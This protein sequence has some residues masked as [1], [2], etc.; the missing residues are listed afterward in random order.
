MDLAAG[1]RLGPYEIVGAIGAGGMG[2]VY[3][4]RDTRLERCVALKILPAHF[5]SNPELKSRFEREARMLSS[6]AHPYIC[7]LYD[8]GSQNG[9]AYLVM[10]LLQ[11]ETLAERL[12]RGALPLSD[13]LKTGIEVADALTSAHRLGLVH[14]DLKPANIMLTKTGA[15][16]MDFGLAKPAS[17]GGGSSSAWQVSG[18]TLTA[19]RSPGTPITRAGSIVGT[20]QY[21]SPEQLEGKEEDARSDI[22]ALGAVLYEMATGKRAFDGRTQLSVVS[23]ILHHEPE[24]IS[25]IQPTSPAALNY[26][27]CTCLRKDPDERF[28]TAHDVKLQLNWLAQGSGPTAPLA[29]AQVAVPRK[30]PWKIAAAVAAA[31]ALLLLGFALARFSGGGR[32]RDEGVTRLT[33]TLPPKQ[34]LGADITMAEAISPDGK[35]LAYVGVESGLSRLYTRR[36]DQFE[37][38]EIP[39]SEGASFPFFSPQGDW[40]AFFSQGKLKKAPADGGVPVVICEMPSFFGGT[41]TPK[42]TVVV[43]VPNVGLATVPAAGGNLEKVPMMAKEA[44]YPEGLTWV[45]GGDWVV[46]TDY[47]PSRRRMLAVK[48]STGEARTLLENASSPAYSAGHLLYYQGGAVWAAPFNEDKVQ[49]EGSAVQLDSGVSEDNYIAQ[50][51]A[52]RNG[53][54]IYAPGLPGNSARNLYVVNRQGQEQKLDVPPKDYIDPVF[55]PDGKRFAVVIRSIQELEVID[56][57]RGSVTNIAPN[58]AN[59]AAVWTPDGKNLLFDA[60]PRSSDKSYRMGGS[61]DRGIYRVAVDGASEPQML[62]TTKQI[63]HVTAVAGEY[64]A[65]M[66]S[67]PETNTDLWLMSVREPFDMKPYKKTT[68][69][70]RQGALSPDGRWMAYSSNDSGRTEIYVEPVPGPGGRRQ[71]STDGGDQPRWVRNGREIIYRN[72]T[73][74]MS[75][76]VAMEPAFQAAKAV[77]LF[78]RKFDTGAAVAGYDVSPDGQTFLMTRSEHENPM[79]IRVVMNWPASLTKQK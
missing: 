76:A 17:L 30:R 4:A 32:G 9:V 6:V 3:R 48:L 74:M 56:R 52:S 66:V 59:F 7:H 77:E 73:K 8:V 22:F 61:E 54:L 64:A 58:L 55:A 71:I 72:G 2:E 34:E 15:K 60:L 70:E 20:I 35:R 11:G 42:E 10:E 67:D 43:S 68:A 23:A 45:G 1:T 29:A 26:I 5:S 19:M 57:E 63:S 41:W 75:V 24:P 44:V 14:R 27:I 37:A 46:F 12:K 38:V 50:I 69:V 51:T 65:V 36:L 40:V 78:D 49:L 25:A 13:V 33:V 21:M 16:L 62:R 31:A 39:E 53:V 28:Q 47:L 79:Q 18:E